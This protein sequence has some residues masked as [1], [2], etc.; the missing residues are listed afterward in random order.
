MPVGPVFRH[1]GIESGKERLEL[2]KR[3]EEQSIG[4]TATKGS[5]GGFRCLQEVR[6]VSVKRK[7]I[8]FIANEVMLLRNTASGS[9]RPPSSAS[10]LATHF[11]QV[12]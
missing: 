8:R 4:R 9:F 6:I 7:P 3:E 10:T 12:R 11:S 1:R 5:K 2:G